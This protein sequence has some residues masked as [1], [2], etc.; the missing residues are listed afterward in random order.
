MQRT[1]SIV[2]VQEG[3]KWW[4]YLPDVPGVYGLGKTEREAKEDLSQALQ[5]YIED[6]LADGDTVPR[7][8]AKRV[9]VDQVRIAV[10]K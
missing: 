2:L 3:R 7:P 6:A 4:A 5:L 8:R 9:E 10:G 1:Y